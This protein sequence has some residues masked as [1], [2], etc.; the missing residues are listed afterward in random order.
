MSDTV[1]PVCPLCDNN[2]CQWEEGLDDW[3]FCPS[4]QQKHLQKL[5]TV[6]GSDI[7]GSQQY[8]RMIGVPE[9][10]FNANLTDFENG[11]KIATIPDGKGALVE[12]KIGAGKTH[13]LCALA[14]YKASMGYSTRFVTCVDIVSHMRELGFAES[15]KYQNELI[16]VD[17]LFLDD[18]G[19][20]G[21]S[22]FVYAAFFRIFNERYN[23]KKETS[24]SLNGK[25]NLVCDDRM[26][27]RI[28]E[29]MVKITL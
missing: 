9:R 2:P 27:R 16:K 23:Q 22:E 17:C 21:N 13:L 28:T 7:I 25:L 5:S 20:Q 19:T 15:E 1:T 4:C 11:G 14:K 18:F 24:I 12:G 29:M 6:I 8:I 10:Y 26:T 3:A